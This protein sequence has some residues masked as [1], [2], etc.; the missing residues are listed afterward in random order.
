MI[1]PALAQMEISLE[2]STVEVGRGLLEN[3]FIVL[4]LYIL[5]SIGVLLFLIFIIRKFFISGSKIF[6][7]FQ[8][9]VLLITVPK[10][11][12]SKE[13]PQKETK[14]L[15][16]QVENL[17]AVLAGL[18]AQRGFEV[19][20]AGR[21]DHFSFEIVASRDGL[22]SFYVAIPRYLQRFAEQ[23]IHAQYP[24]AYIEEVEDY[25]IFSPQGV[26]RGAALSLKR[27]YIFPIKTYAKINGDPLNALTNA[28]SKLEKGE[29]ACIQIVAR[30]AYAI[31][32]KKGAKV[33]S[34]MQQGKRLKEVLRKVEGGIFLNFLWNMFPAKPKKTKEG[35]PQPQKEIYQLSPMEQEIVKSLEEKTS[36]AGF[37]VCIRIITSG[38]TEEIAERNLSV[39]LNSFSGYSTYEYGNSFKVKRLGKNVKLINNFIYRHFD[40]KRKFILNTE[41]MASL[42]HLPL[43][44][45]ETPNIKWLQAK[46]APAPTDVPKEGLL[47][48]TNVYRGVETPIRIKKDDRRRHVYII[49]KSGVGKSWLIQNLVRQDIQN[50]EGVCVIDPHGDLVEGILESIP[51]ERADDVVI[52][53]PSDMARPVGLNMLE[54]KTEEEKDFAVQEMISIFYKLFSAEMIGPMFEH[55]MRNV[56]LTLMADSVNPGTIAEIPRMFTDT[57]FQNYWIEKLTDPVVKT[58]WE[59]EMAKTSDFHKSEMLGYLISKVGRFVENEMMRNIIGQTH[60]GFNF[61]DIMDNKK[62]LL[63]NLAKGKTGEVNSN[64]LGLIIVS[65]LQMAAMARAEL[66]EEKRHDFYL[67][68]DEFQNFITPSI[69]TILSEARKYRLNLIIAHQYI[70]QLVVG[71]DTKIRDAVFG[72]AGTM[73]SFKIGVEDA[74]IMAKEFAPVFNEYDVINVERYNAYVK[75]LIDNQATRAFNIRALPVERGNPEFAK[76]IK[77]L[78]RLKYGQDRKIVEEDI[79]RRTRLGEPEARQA[80]AIGE[81]NL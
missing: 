52:F 75:L 42:W 47:L 23:Q 63:I 80:G 6:S 74:E 14:D 30:S 54:A 56:M 29:G 31:W 10:E 38:K 11:Q 65:K 76:S 4:S 16:S 44:T 58:F 79:L 43:P 62:I 60:S 55:N 3:P 77:E 46:K 5:A 69:G 59:K 61:R 28:L 73:I 12:G 2:S 53:D 19:F 22:I 41:E 18:R 17:F 71:N 26:I 25:N 33:A 57:E 48:G 35:F 81:R 20:L 49:G 39:I 9:V 40:E 45:T 51:K 1:Y 32:H 50:G 37:D 72:N 8:K 64:L 24:N 36:K 68:I 27:N 21:Q 13:E 78:S 70:G 15:I 66:P 67:Y 34:E 7:S